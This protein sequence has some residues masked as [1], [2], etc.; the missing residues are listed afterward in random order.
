M[1]IECP[2]WEKP[3]TNQQLPHVVRGLVDFHRFVFK[4]AKTYILTHGDLKNWHGR[5]FQDVVPV[6]YYAGNYRCNDPN[7]PCLAENVR[8][9]NNFGAPFAEVPALMQQLSDSMVDL[10]IRTDKFIASGATP[11]DRAR[12]A[13][14]LAAAYMGKLI[15]IHPFL[16]GNGRLARVTA[17]YF[18]HRYGFPLFF[19]SA[20]AR[21]GGEYP[22]ASEV[23]MSGDFVLIYRYLL[24][25][26]AS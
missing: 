8:V 16:N 22:R 17:N 25:S 19:P 10:T 5:I 4:K 23:C 21:P 6:P 7:R 14:Q 24:S 20:Y 13:V 15:Q 26:L 1:P 12:A 11:T 9:G 18:L 2:K 3:E